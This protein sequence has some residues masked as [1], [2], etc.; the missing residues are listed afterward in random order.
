MNSRPRLDPFDAAVLVCLI[1]STVF[2][3]VIAVV[4]HFEVGHAVLVLWPVLLALSGVAWM[5]IEMWVPTDASLRRQALGLLAL[6]AVQALAAAPIVALGWEVAGGHPVLA[7]AGATG[8]VFAG[9][10]VFAIIKPATEVEPIDPLVVLAL[11]VFATLMM[12]LG[13]GL[14]VRFVVAA[15]V[16]AVTGILALGEIS[17]V[18][19]YGTGAAVAGGARLFSCVSVLFGEFLYYFVSLT[20]GDAWLWDA[21]AC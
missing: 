8:L 5:T 6:V 20:R 1:A 13:L 9:L 12:G 4:V 14:P 3:L 19:A 10:C 18:A 16:V 11:V 2:G 21:I 17:K 7:S 15:P